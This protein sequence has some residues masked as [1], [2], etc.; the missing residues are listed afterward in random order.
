MATAQQRQLDRQRAED[1]LVAR[2][3]QAEGA[4]FADKD[5][6]VTP[7]YLAQQEEFRR[8]EEEERKKAEK[9]PTNE[10]RA[11]LYK[12][13]LDE[14]SRRHE[15][16]MKAVEK[17]NAE[18]QAAASGGGSLGLSALL[19]DQAASSA[20]PQAPQYDAEPE[21]A[22]DEV[23]VAEEASKRLG[24]KID[25]DDEGRIVDHRQLL[26]GGLNVG[27]RKAV[28]GPSRDRGFALPIAQR[29][30]EDREKLAAQAKSEMN[31]VGE[32][33]LSRADKIRLSRERQSRML[34]QQLV[35]L[36]QKKR[37]AEEDKLEE[38]VKKVAKRNDESRVEELKRKALER[39]KQRE[40]M[41]KSS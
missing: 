4:D 10:G 23:K 1:A 19:K 26:T 38:G 22:P 5:A 40:D 20:K 16:A 17:R 3:R 36:E 39:R 2:E 21:S 9:G 29:A 13:L 25:M 6:F 15:A 24:R 35:E 28:H 32:D 30:Q 34:E 27:S 11:K 18:K 14:D 33:G 31:E 12:G 37:K 8:L 7:A 41:A